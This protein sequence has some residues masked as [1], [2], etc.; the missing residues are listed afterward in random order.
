MNKFN[1]EVNKLITRKISPK[2]YVVPNTFTNEERIQLLEVA[3]FVQKIIE[4]EKKVIFWYRTVVFLIFC[5]LLLG[6]VCYS[7]FLIILAPV[8]AATAYHF[9]PYYTISLTKVKK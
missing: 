4:Q 9:E 3:L 6:I 7:P 2:N 5:L 1:E 8:F